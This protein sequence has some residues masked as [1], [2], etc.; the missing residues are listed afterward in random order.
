[1]RKDLKTGM[2]AGLVLVIV[3]TIWLSMRPSLT[4]QSRAMQK[5]LQQSP[6]DDSNSMQLI[7]EAAGINEPYFAKPTNLPTDES[8]AK[9]TLAVDEQAN[10]VKT[11]AV[12][13]VGAG[14]T[15][16]DIAKIYYG[17]GSEWPRIYKANKALL[18]S[19]PGALKPG[20]RLNIPPAN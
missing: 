7:D 11:P 6:S 15:L 18:K 8:T 16:S 1:M 20:M 19:G 5:N 10:K 13:I 14:E 17:A 4:V 2:L 12:H 9:D 3:I